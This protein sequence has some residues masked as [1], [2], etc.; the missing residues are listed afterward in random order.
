MRRNTPGI[1]GCCYY[2][3]IIITQLRISN[4]TSHHITSFHISTIIIATG[5]TKHISQPHSNPRAS[6][7]PSH[8]H[9]TIES[10]AIPSDPKRSQAIPGD[11]RW[12][13]V[14]PSDPRRPQ[15]IHRVLVLKNFVSAGA[16]FT[17]LSEPKPSIL[18][19]AV[20]YRPI[21]GFSKKKNNQNV[22]KNTIK[23]RQ[24]LGVKNGPKM[25]S[26][27][28]SHSRWKNIC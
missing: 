7:I 8:P 16:D 20:Q 2:Y 27:I 1:A 5:I 22:H 19:Q 11:P 12:S 14:I 26:D 6:S 25:E 23:N 24:I 17:D 10:Q 3:Y 18:S 9:P 4:S 21:L 13:Q 15:A 28:F